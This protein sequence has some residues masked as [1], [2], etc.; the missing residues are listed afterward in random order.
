MP[1]QMWLHW[2]PVTP[3]VWPKNYPFIDGSKRAAFLATGL[4]L[5]LN[6]YRLNASQAEAT[7]TI[8]AVATGN[9]AADAF[10][11]WLRDHTYKKMVE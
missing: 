3:Q 1:L 6:G 11:E 7:I 9:I 8:L 2:R 4:F 10:T 5:Y